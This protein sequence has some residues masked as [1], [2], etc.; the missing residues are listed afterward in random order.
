VII[1]L[2]KNIKLPVLIGEPLHFRYDLNGLTKLNRPK[3]SEDHSAFAA[4]DITSCC[5]IITK[6]K[7][8]I[9]I[10]LV[11]NYKEI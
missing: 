6:V 11:H 5:V 9:G 4:E 3:K 8:P 10:Y 2:H 7:S 1:K